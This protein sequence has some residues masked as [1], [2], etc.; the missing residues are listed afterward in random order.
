MSL[1]VA[2]TPVAGHLE[3][4]PGWR[5]GRGAFGGLCVAAMIRAVQQVE[6]IDV[7]SVTAE[8]FAP[9][10]VGP[11]ELPVEVLRRGSSVTVARAQIVQGEPRAH[12]VVLLGKPR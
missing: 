7:R 3:I 4:E 6:P 9:V 1:D 8:L 2:S 10:E 5:Q 11:A 12:A